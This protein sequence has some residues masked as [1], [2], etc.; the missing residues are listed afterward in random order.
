MPI[1]DPEWASISS[2]IEKLAGR[3]SGKRQDWFV[4]GKVIKVD[5]PNRLV[6]LAEFGDQAIPIVA[7][8]Y[9]MDYYDTDGTGAVQKK[10]ATVTVKMPKVGDTVV[11]ARE[12]AT[13]RLPRAIGILQG[14]NWITPEEE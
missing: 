13:R 9:T 1:T 7:F 11:V 8:D 5:A 14:K 3:I 10:T 12:L 4:T 2:L 6:Y